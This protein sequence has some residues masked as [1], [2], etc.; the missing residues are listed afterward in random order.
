MDGRGDNEELLARPG[1]E[2]RDIPADDPAGV[3]DV[4][5]ALYKETK[6]DYNLVI[7]PFG[8]KPQVVGV[9]LFH[10]EH[11]AAQVIYSFPATYT[12]SYLQ[13]QPGETMLLPPVNW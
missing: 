10:R 7:G 11:P 9:Y 5:A 13:R 6:D 3:R 2:V 8:T 4:L 12:R 1:V